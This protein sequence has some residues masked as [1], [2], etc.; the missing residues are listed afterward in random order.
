[1]NEIIRIGFRGN[2]VNISL[3]QSGLIQTTK[4]IFSRLGLNV[5]DKISDEE[6][7]SL[8][9]FTLLSNAKHTANRLLAI[10]DHSVYEIRRKLLQ[11]KFPPKIIDEVIKSL[12]DV[13]LLNDELFAEKFTEELISRK[14]F[15]PSRIRIELSKR[16]IANEIIDQM[17]N[18]YFAEKNDTKILL[19]NT[20]EKYLKKG[21]DLSNKNELAKLY[22]Y[23]SRSGFDYSLIRECVSEIMKTDD[24]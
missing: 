6:I 9:Y 19:R 5:G 15:G 10:R 2:R 24:I 20:A 21:K 18:K 17:L 12:F 22:N 11:K 4:E 1:M 13:N 16:G 8:K 23:L 14:K 3:S 7:L